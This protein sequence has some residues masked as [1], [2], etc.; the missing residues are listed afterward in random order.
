[1]RSLPRGDARRCSGAPA[2]GAG[3]AAGAL[4][5]PGAPDN[6]G[7]SHLR[8]ADIRLLRAISIARSITGCA[9]FLIL[10]HSRVRPE[11]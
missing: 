11:R 4:N 2:A 7:Q 3:A 6:S 1:M 8:R 10:I 5:A 9:G